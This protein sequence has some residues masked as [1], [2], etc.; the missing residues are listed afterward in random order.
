MKMATDI[1]NGTPGGN[2]LNPNSEMACHPETKIKV[3][4]GLVPAS[5]VKLGTEL[6]HGKVVGIVKKECS[7]ICEVG[8]EF[9]AAGSCLWSEA[10]GKWMRAFEISRPVKIIPSSYY[11][12]VVTPSA[13]IETE[14]NMFRDY[15]EV[16]SKDLETPYSNA[17]G[18]NTKP[19]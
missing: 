8:G 4:D 13:C 11:S 2:L 9:F 10:H 16:H 12:F 19:L 7:E 5:L 6:S 14:K 15:V 1:L 18:A 17:L 3:K